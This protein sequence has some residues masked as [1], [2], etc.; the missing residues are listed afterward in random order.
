MNIFS[1]LHSK[2]RAWLRAV[3]CSTWECT[4]RNKKDGNIVQEVSDG[5]SQKLLS[6]TLTE[7]TS[8]KF[9]QDQIGQA[10]RNALF[11]S[12]QCQYF[13]FI[14]FHCAIL[15]LSEHINELFHRMS[16]LLSDLPVYLSWGFTM[17]YLLK[18]NKMQSFSSALIYQC[19]DMTVK[20]K[21]VLLMQWT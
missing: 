1:S 6:F 9:N 17:A 7:S 3:F 12:S 4:G 15:Q 2:L 10:L 16:S 21:L 18:G 20:Y 14:F 5:K 13:I 19:T 8:L 11:F